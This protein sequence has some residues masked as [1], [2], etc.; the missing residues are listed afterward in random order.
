MKLIYLDL[1]LHEMWPSCDENKAGSSFF[2]DWVLT[3]TWQ[4]TMMGIHNLQSGGK[5]RSK[6]HEFS[7]QD[8][9]SC[10]E[11]YIPCHTFLEFLHS[12]KLQFSKVENSVCLYIVSNNLIQSLQIHLEKK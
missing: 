6:S 10:Y 9:F 8:L 12:Q 5:F 1:W 4:L 3:S 2:V 7:Y 11:I